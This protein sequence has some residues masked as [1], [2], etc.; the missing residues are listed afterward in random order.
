MDRRVFPSGQIGVESKLQLAY[1]QLVTANKVTITEGC[2]NIVHM[3]LCQRS[4]PSCAG[5][6]TMAMSLCQDQ[7]DLLSLAKLCQDQCDLLSLAKLCLGE[8]LAGQLMD[9]V[10]GAILQCDQRRSANHLCLPLPSWEQF[11]G[12]MVVD[13]QGTHHMHTCAAV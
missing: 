11:E 3:F 7:C 12:K 9:A 1:N 2:S 6:A 10:P 5:N 13:P 8:T 4:L